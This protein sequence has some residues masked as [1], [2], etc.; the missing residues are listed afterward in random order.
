MLKG[1]Y[2]GSLED[3]TGGKEDGDP[4]GVLANF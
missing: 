2:L 4:G 3:V 1:T